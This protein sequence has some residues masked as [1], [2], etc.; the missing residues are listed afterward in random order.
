MG[1]TYLDFQ[2]LTKT[3]ASSYSLFPAIKIAMNQVETT[4][5]VLTFA[6][7]NFRE[8][9]EIK[10]TR[11]FLERVIRENKYTRNFSEIN[12]SRNT[13][14]K[15]RKETG[16]DRKNVISMKSESF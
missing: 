2:P 15:K 11:N 5:S 4:L 7:T 12:D 16:K 1:N 10:Y 8:F 13:G 3:G 14:E 9:R 6:C